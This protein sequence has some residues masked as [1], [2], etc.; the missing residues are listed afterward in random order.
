MEEN[1][2]M[3]SL[4]TLSPVSLPV[5]SI[6][7]FLTFSP[8]SAYSLHANDDDFVPL[9]PIWPVSFT[10]SFNEEM[11]FVF[12]TMTTSGE[13]FYDSLN[14]RLRIDRQ[15][16]IGD[17]FCGTAYPFRNTQCSHIVLDGVRYLVFPDYSYC[18]KCCTAAQGCGTPDQ[19]WLVNATYVG[20]DYIY[21]QKCSKW[22]TG[23]GLTTYYWNTA[24]GAP[25]RITVDSTEQMTF[26]HDSF[27]SSDDA[28]PDK[29]FE[30]PP[31]MDCS[32]SC[33]GYCAF[34]FSGQDQL[35][36]GGNIGLAQMSRKVAREK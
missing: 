27:Q 25:V 31:D 12:V 29:I 6:L 10:A 3:A 2:S 20:Q 8:L 14:K 33:Y 21:G 28:L 4:L 34:M 19:D 22:I 17:R 11:Y 26:V 35:L 1:D 24:D 30:L 18:C 7:L 23:Q 9:A 32:V 5:L 15:N 13:Y 16:G 36:P